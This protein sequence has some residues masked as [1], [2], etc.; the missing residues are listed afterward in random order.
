[1]MCKEKQWHSSVLRIRKTIEQG[2]NGDVKST[3][4]ALAG[5]I[6]MWIVRTGPDMTDRKFIQKDLQISQTWHHYAGRTKAR[7]ESQND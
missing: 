3:I 6:R 7:A 4:K 1:M 5:S 2:P